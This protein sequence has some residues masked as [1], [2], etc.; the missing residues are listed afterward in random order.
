MNNISSIWEKMKS[1]FIDIFQREI[2]RNI[3]HSAENDTR[4]NSKLLIFLITHSIFR[5]KSTLFA[6]RPVK[7]THGQKQIGEKIGVLA[8][9][10]IYIFST[11]VFVDKI[12]KFNCFGHLSDF[13][14]FFDVDNLFPEILRHGQKDHFFSGI[15]FLL[16]QSCD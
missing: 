1:T 3:L 14:D 8:A 9:A 7:S 6:K 13:I 15:C 2:E 5:L 4:F 12:E 11:T 16:S 10:S